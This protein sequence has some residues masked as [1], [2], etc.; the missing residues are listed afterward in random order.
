[1]HRHIFLTSLLLSAITASAQQRP[2]RLYRFEK[3]NLYGFTNEKRDTVLPAQFEKASKFDN[4]G[5]AMVKIN[6]K[7]GIINLNGEYIVPAEYDNLSTPS[8]EGI[9]VVIRDS[10]TG[11]RNINT[12]KIISEV[13]WEH[14]SVFR[15]GFARV[16]KN[17]HQGIINPEGTLVCPTVYDDINDVVAD[18]M[19]KVTKDN[20]LG[21]IDARTWNL[22]VPTIWSYARDFNEGYA[23]VKLANGHFAFINKTGAVAINVGPD[24]VPSDFHEGLAGVVKYKKVGFIDTRGKLAIAFAWEDAL[25]FRYGRAAVKH[26]GKWGYI[27]KAGKMLIKPTYDQITSD[28]QYEAQGSRN[29]TW[30]IISFPG[31]PLQPEPPNSKPIPTP[32]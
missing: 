8:E 26:N 20:K 7:C 23:I 22:T 3:N 21:F 18:G 11:Y 28:S 30:E 31:S 12:G 19:I 9:V 6:G 29:G 27:D 2:T 5:T 10:L 32:R 15:D 16:T 17:K 24:I 13:R 4:T 25:P 1:M 14:G